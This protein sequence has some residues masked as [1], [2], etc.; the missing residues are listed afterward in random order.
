[1]A[2]TQSRTA[3]V[4]KKYEEDLLSEWM[5]H[6]QATGSGKD[7]RISEKDLRGQAKEFLS[8]LQHAAQA[9][10]ISDTTGPHWKEVSAFLDELSKQRVMQGFGAD[11]TAL[12]VFSLK[13]P[14]F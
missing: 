10:D 7:S 4:L 3:L 6:L 8:L 12:F 14:L 9:G 1:M 11:Q 5:H 2:K 13:K